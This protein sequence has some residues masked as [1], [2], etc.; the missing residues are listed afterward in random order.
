MGMHSV[1]IFL[2]IAGAAGLFL[3]AIGATAIFTNS[4][5]RNFPGGAGPR[6]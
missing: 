5:A 2:G 4:L 6:R 3:L 1:D